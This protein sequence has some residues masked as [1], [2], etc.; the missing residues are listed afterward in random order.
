[1]G[2]VSAQVDPVY[3]ATGKSALRKASLR[4]VPLIAFG[5]CA[6]F[7][8]RVNISFAAPSM[9]RDL[10][11]SASM[12]GLGAGMFF[13]SYALCEVPSNLLLVRFGARRWLARIMFTWGL[14]AMGMMF[15]HTAMQFYVMR[16]LLGIA[17]AGFFPGVV[18]YL[19]EWF[20]PEYRARTISR[21]YVSLPLGSTVMG[22]LAGALLSLNGRFSLRGWQWLFLVEGLP[23]LLL[24][25]LFWKYLPDKPAEAA[26]LKTDERQWLENR[27][28][29]STEGTLAATH[30]AADLLGV[31][32]DRRVWIIAGLFFC[33]L[34]VMYAWQFSA[35]VILQA[36]TG[37]TIGRV[38][39]IIAIFGLL[40]AAA[41]LLNA[42]HSD[43]ARE[44]PL[45]ISLPLLVMGAGFLIGGLTTHT[46]LALPAFAL[47][48]IGYNAAQGPAL[49]LPSTFLS[50]RTSAIGYAFMNMI[51]MAG[52]FVGPYW[53]G[54][55]RDLTGN[56]QHGLL[57]LTVPPAIAA[58]LIYVLH[59]KGASTKDATP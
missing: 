41:M 29:Q 43:H 10:H 39:E 59:R 51:G 38:G 35:P 16:F 2:A 23:P 13:I 4:L 17:E 44:R 52:G 14:L 33:E 49:S 8:D 46:L 5:Y 11:F 21:F 58:V 37:L 25:L 32:R 7:I 1:M 36:D 24:S 27:L 54:R 55:V 48:Y 50:G 42:I 15:V 6:A 34:S 53:M 28:A 31:V 20:P 12:Y 30:T 3:G 47:V 19:T 26:W 18:F 22:S 57:T 40:G 45:H 9:N 56:Y